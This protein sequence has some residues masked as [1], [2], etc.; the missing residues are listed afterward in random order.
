[1]AWYALLVVELLALLVVVAVAR[2]VDGPLLAPLLSTV[3][4]LV[5]SAP[6]LGRWVHPVPPA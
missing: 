5:L 1:M 2:A 3:A 4:L 6:S